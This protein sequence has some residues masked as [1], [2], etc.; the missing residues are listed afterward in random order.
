MVSVLA[1]SWFALRNRVWN[2]KLVPVRY[3][4]AAAAKNAAAVL[5]V[6]AAASL[7]AA[8]AAMMLAVQEKATAW[9]VALGCIVRILG[10]LVSGEN[11]IDQQ[12]DAVDLLL[13]VF[14]SFPRR[15][16]LLLLDSDG[17]N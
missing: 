9:H 2:A 15:L 7:P 5:S 1:A 6:T 17:G 8:A 13:I 10:L 14:S 11:K 16:L 4:A 3:A 12:L